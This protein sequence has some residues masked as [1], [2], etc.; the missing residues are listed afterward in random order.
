M[1]Y[2]SHSQWF[3]GFYRDPRDFVQLRRARRLFD[4]YP[5]WVPR[6]KRKAFN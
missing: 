4:T 3:G 2:V 1:K 5:E 6:P